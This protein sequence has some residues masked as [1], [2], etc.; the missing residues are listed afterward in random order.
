MKITHGLA[1][2]RLPSSSQTR[3]SPGKRAVLEHHVPGFHSR[4]PAPAPTVPSV[5]QP[6]LLPPMCAR[7]HIPKIGRAPV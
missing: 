3:R 4:A 6:S 7:P 1:V 2:V 5:P